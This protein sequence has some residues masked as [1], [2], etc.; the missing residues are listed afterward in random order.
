[1]K[2]ILIALILI[3]GFAFPAMSENVKHE[4][5]IIS[6]G[7]L[8]SLQK[9]KTFNTKGAQ[10]ENILNE[11]GKDGW[12]ISEIFAVRTTFDPNVFFV[13]MKREIK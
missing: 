3:L 11:Y 2:K 10:L 5:K 9:E 13:I 6:L 1:M 12:D 4:Y 8:T 7:S